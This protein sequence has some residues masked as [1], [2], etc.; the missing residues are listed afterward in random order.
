MCLQDADVL[1]RENI[2]AWGLAFETT[3]DVVVEVFIDGILEHYSA[4]WA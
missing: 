2:E 3:N 4:P 1:N